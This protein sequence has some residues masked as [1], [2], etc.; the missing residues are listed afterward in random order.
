MGLSKP[1]AIQ[2]YNREPLSSQSFLI[3]GMRRSEACSSAC[4]PLNY[5]DPPPFPL[6]TGILLKQLICLFSPG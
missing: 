3:L 6:V 2:A 1:C 5:V 4:S